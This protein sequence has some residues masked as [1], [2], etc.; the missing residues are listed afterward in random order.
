M[1]ETI[2]VFVEQARYEEPLPLWR[3]FVNPF[4]RLLGLPACPQSGRAPCLVIGIGPPK[5]LPGPK[6]DV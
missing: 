2:L 1:D 3:R 6:D 4:R 5:Q